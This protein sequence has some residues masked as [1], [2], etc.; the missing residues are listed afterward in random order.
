MAIRPPRSTRP[1]R[2]SGS[3]RDVVVVLACS[4]VIAIV[5]LRVLV[6][7]AGVSTSTA[8]WIVVG[9]P[10]EPIIGLIERAD[11][12][13]GRIVGRLSVGELVIAIAIWV[14]CLVVIAW[15]ALQR[16]P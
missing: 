9:E 8:A 12:L 6:D 13:D 7:G 5:L 11:A 4:F 15:R 2:R 10:T 16:R 1:R 14:V 3:T